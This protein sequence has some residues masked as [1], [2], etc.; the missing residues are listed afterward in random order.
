MDNTIF[1]PGDV[2]ILKSGG[3]PMTIL[4]SVD[5]ANLICGLVTT[6]VGYTMHTIPVVALRRLH[7][8]GTLGSR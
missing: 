8:D 7:T 2:V 5:D 1:E 3:P 4:D 6:H